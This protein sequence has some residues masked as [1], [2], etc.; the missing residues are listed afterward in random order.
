L[1]FFEVRRSHFIGHGRA[2]LSGG[3]RPAMLPPRPPWESHE[4]VAEQASRAAA[5]ARLTPRGSTAHARGSG[6]CWKTDRRPPSP[7]SAS[8][9]ETQEKWDRRPSTAVPQTSPPPK[10]VSARRISFGT[11]YDVPRPRRL[12]VAEESSVAAPSARCSGSS[13]FCSDDLVNLQALC[14]ARNLATGGL[15]PRR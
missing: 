6:R 4:L 11:G 12:V 7:R 10:S 14:A 8:S 3:R 9:G 15:S 5:H 2:V 1:P 13:R